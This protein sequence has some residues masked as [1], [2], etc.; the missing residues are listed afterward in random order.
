MRGAGVGGGS[1][2]THT[3]RVKF[4]LLINAA[5]LALLAAM[6]TYVVGL[7]E[8]HFFD[9]RSEGDFCTAKPLSRTDPF[10]GATVFPLSQKCR[11]RDGTTSDLV[12][13]YVNPLIVVLVALGVLLLVLAAFAAVRKRVA[14]RRR[15]EPAGSPL[16]M[17]VGADRGE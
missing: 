14:R 5:L 11:W 2:G 7:A 17:A 3:A 10:G 6:G 1:N 8:G 16:E 13:S 12:P 15:A 9:L 4:L